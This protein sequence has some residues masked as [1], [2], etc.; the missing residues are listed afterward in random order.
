MLIK[1]ERCTIRPFEE[2]DIDEFIT[3]RNDMDW[4]RYQGFKGLEKREYMNALLGNISL[5]NGLQLAIVCNKTHILIGD[6]YMKEEDSTYWIGYTISRPKAHQGYAYEAV[7]AVINVLR[8]K[9]GA[10]CIKAGV[11][12]GNA[13]SI[14]LLEKLKFQYLE[15][16]DDELIYIL[17]FD[18]V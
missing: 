12:S 14:A 13:A 15:T 10:T 5:C 18:S 3:Y 2:S 1:T 7:S 9:K 6:V 8:K 11:E 17:S 16:L 4:M